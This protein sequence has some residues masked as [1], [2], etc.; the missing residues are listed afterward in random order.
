MIHWRKRI[1][2]RLEALLA[3]ILRVGHATGA[4]K[5]KDLERITVNTTVQP[6]AI[7]FPADRS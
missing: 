5:P 7:T 4:V 1:G 2:D 6:K 3:E